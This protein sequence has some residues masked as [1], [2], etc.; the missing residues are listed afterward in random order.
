MRARTSIVLLTLAATALGNLPARAQLSPPEGVAAPAENGV[1]AD[2]AGYEVLTRGPVHEAFAEVAA[3]TPEAGVII[4]REPPQPIEEQP[5]EMRPEGE[6]VVWLPGYWHWDDDRQDFL[7]VSGVW[8]AVPPDREWTP[9]YWRQAEGGFQWVAGYWAGRGA[10]SA[11]VQYLPPPPDSLEA[12]PTSPAPGDDYVWSPGCWVWQTRYV[13]RPGSWI[14]VRPN[15]IWI[16]HYYVWTPYGCV[17]AGGYMDYPVPRRGLLFAPIYFASPIYTRPAFA[18]R[19]SYCIG[20]DVLTTYLFARPRSCHYYFGDYFAPR[21]AGIGYQPWFQSRWGRSNYD[22]LFAHYR[23]VNRRNDRNWDRRLVDRYAFLRDNEGARPP[24]TFAAQQAGLARIARDG[25]PDAAR[26]GG[27]LQIAQSLDRFRQTAGNRYGV[28]LGQVSPEQ[29]ERAKE[30]R[31]SWQDLQASRRKTENRDGAAGSPAA[32]KQR[33]PR[34]ARWNAENPIARDVPNVRRPDVP[35]GPRLDQGLA[36]PGRGPERGRGLDNVGGGRGAGD[37]ASGDNAAADSATP[38]PDLGNLNRNRGSQ[39]RDRGNVGRIPRDNAL[40]PDA[41]TGTPGAGQGG[42]Q[43][44]FRPIPRP[45]VD[46]Q[47]GGPANRPDF[48]RPAEARSPRGRRPSGAPDTGN[49]ALSGP[50]RNPSLGRPQPD[51]ADRFRGPNR[52]NFQQPTT[53][54]LQ[55]PRDNALRAPRINQPTSPQFTPQ[56]RGGRSMTPDRGALQRPRNPSQPSFDRSNVNRQTMQ[57]PLG[58]PAGNRSLNRS[59]PAARV[60]PPARSPQNAAPR[61]NP[62]Q[63][64][65]PMASDASAGGSPRGRSARP[66]VGGSGNAGGGQPSAAPRGRGRDRGD[67]DES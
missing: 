47:P 3:A 25:R 37:S 21:Y 12:G 66:E 61:P 54:P 59:A 35:R 52:G 60:Q 5:P 31:R 14:V 7:W 53:P 43:Q 51:R 32:G 17:L 24:R 44:T 19:P 46:T 8:R 29:F 34:R 22:P 57:R 39:G 6:N 41:G 10:A 30:R 65:R 13:W 40:R 26:R 2:A 45:G 4:P 23:S 1:S 63:F 56:P 55:A 36:Q 9:G 15:W 11:E 48:G 58:P 18:Y 67:R 27:E 38:K 64:R 20:F 16:P 42:S 33:D 50:T 49:S 62:S 28:Q